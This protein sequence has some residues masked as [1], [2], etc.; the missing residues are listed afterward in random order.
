MSRRPAP[1][2]LH[3]VLGIM[4][5]VAFAIGPLRGAPLLMIVLPFSP[6]PAIVAGVVL[7]RPAAKAA[8]LLLAVGS[9]LFCAGDIY[10]Y[11]Y[12]TL[13]GAALPFPSPGDALYL[14]VY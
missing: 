11:S 5:C 7:H 4:A 9:V 10:T 2:S 14:A 8:W 3:L 1:W 13:S 6:V 12:P